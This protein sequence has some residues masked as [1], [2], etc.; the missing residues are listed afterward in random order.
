M[1]ITPSGTGRGV[2]TGVG[3]GVG[4]NVAV[5]EG[6]VVGDEAPIV[7][8]SLVVALTE[9]NG[10]SV[11]ELAGCVCP[12]HATRAL[13]NSTISETTSSG[14][15]IH[16]YRVS[17]LGHTGPVLIRLYHSD[18]GTTTTCEMPRARSNSQAHWPLDPTHRPT[19]RTPSLARA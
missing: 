3:L 7:G 8:V 18:I 17:D 4:V 16:S 14:F 19:T 10:P 5:G 11:G 15:V 6:A 2:G 12:P 13:P 1:L 9:G